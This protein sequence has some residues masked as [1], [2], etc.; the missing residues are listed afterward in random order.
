V[1]N[2]LRPVFEDYPNSSKKVMGFFS[3]KLRKLERR[4]NSLDYP[5][6]AIIQPVLLVSLTDVL[7]K[8]HTL[9]VFDYLAA[10]PFTP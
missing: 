8:Q 6:S 9:E 3:K 4:V 10:H 7:N 2:W 5:L 1:L